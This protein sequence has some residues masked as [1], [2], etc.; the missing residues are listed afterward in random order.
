M[1]HIVFAVLLTLFCVGNLKAQKNII[2]KGNVTGMPKG[3]NKLYFYGTTFTYDSAIV[4]N[5]SFEFKVPFK[6]P[7]IILVCDEYSFKTNHDH[8]T[9]YRLITDRPGTLVLK[10]VD[11]SKGIKVGRI[12]GS[13]A[14]EDFQ[15]LK[16]L[17]IA[18]R[19]R[20]NEAITKKYGEKRPETGSTNY[21]EYIQYADSLHKKSSHELYKNFVKNHPDSY[22]STFILN[23]GGAVVLNTDE[24]EAIFK[25]LSPAQQQSEG[26]KKIAAYLGGLQKSKTG[27]QVKDFTL[28]DVN[29][30]PVTFSHLKGKY[31]L[32]DFWA[33]YC[34]P[35]IAEFPN[36]KELYKKYKGDQFEI[37]TISVDNN[38]GFWIKESQKQQ[39]PWPSTLDTK[40]ISR[41]EFAVGGIPDA[42]LIDPDGRI[43]LRS[44]VETG[45]KAIKEKI[46]ELF[47]KEKI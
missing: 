5:G 7:G 33:S 25:M 36:L 47:D 22:A 31:V 44:S 9:W 11:L 27:K 37:Y 3:Y 14:A 28:N 16:S 42:F 30:K 35:C 13:Q 8:P 32:V 23:S 10:D 40:G 12:S 38:K 43:I 46:V 18:T 29:G 2:I 41:A 15:D 24:G 39:F 20:T 19:K 26:G 34:A 21:K 6:K 45:K 1:R 17:E 4:A